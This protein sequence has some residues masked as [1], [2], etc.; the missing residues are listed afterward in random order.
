MVDEGR[1]ARL[2]R[3][4]EERLDRLEQARDD[5][6][7][8]RPEPIWLDGVKY[9]FV[10]AIEGCIDVGHHL[11]A[12]ERWGAPDSNAD[13]FRLLAEHGV[14]APELAHRLGRAVRFRNVL[15]HQY[16]VV[17]DERVVAFLDELGDLRAFVERVSAW[18]VR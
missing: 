14:L 6:A 1:V 4:I 18:V 3:S 9:L 16:A 10:T 17:D 11:A 8:R 13:T 15:V 12:A 5:V 2:L 7:P